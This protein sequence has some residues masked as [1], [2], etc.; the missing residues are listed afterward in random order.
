MATKIN[1]KIRRYNLVS[2]KSL[3]LVIC[4]LEG[5]SGLQ[6]LLLPCP[7]KAVTGIDCPGC[8]FQRSLVALFQGNWTESYHLYPPTVPLLVVF[9]Y[10]IFKWIFGFDKQ[11]T[12]MKIIAVLC[13]WFVLVV[14]VLKLFGYTL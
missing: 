9:S 6:K 8:G 14:Y 10:A 2:T 1:R 5:F 3:V 13:G 12:A 7:L 11:D 4:S